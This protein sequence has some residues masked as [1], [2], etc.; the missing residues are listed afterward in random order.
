MNPQVRAMAKSVRQERLNEEYDLVKSI[1][2][3]TIPPYR[4]LEIGCG[5]L[6]FLR[7]RMDQ[8]RDLYSGSI[9][10]DINR[11]ALAQ[12]KQI[13]YPVC[14][15]CYS[16]P[17]ESNSINI[18][19]C[20]WLWEHLAYPETAMQE[21][22]RVLRKDGHVFITTPNLKNY[23]ILVSYLT[24][25]WFHNLLRLITGK[26]ENTRTFYRANTKHRLIRLAS[27]YGFEIRHMGFRPRS[28][29][30]YS[31]SK[32]LFFG[33]KWLSDAIPSTQTQLHL[34]IVCIM[35]KP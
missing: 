26:P 30:Y 18:V 13:R 7:R 15:S 1:K 24:P 19:V 32:M 34:K 3:E 29:M 20:R 2:K 23:M 17:I 10:I 11:Q 33:M 27:K 16:L 28:F 6:G 5:S 4:F 35:R 14:A 12:N 25:T 21:I 22:H 9:G 31:F 8:L